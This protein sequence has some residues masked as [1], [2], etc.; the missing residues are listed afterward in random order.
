MSESQDLHILKD[1]EYIKPNYSSE[2]LYQII[3]QGSIYKT[4]QK[5]FIAE[6]FRNIQKT[7]GYDNAPPHSLVIPPIQY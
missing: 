7:R 3:L 5:A 1:F 6:K 2:K 4:K